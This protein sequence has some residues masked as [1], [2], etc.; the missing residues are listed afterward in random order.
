MHSVMSWISLSYSN[1]KAKFCIICVVFFFVF[2]F[3]AKSLHIFY[4]K[5]LVVALGTFHLKK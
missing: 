2:F 3:S 5:K 1:E 4:N